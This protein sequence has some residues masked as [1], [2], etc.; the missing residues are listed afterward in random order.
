M[1]EKCFYDN[2]LV[3]SLQNLDLTKECDCM[4]KVN[5]PKMCYAASSLLLLG[6]II[7]T[8]VDYYRYYNTNTLTSAPFYLLVVVNI[9]YFIVPAIITL[10]IGIVVKCKQ[11]QTPKRRTHIGIYM[12]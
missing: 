4:K 6:F 1:C 11:K 7:H 8:I 2:M 10:V 5:V 9:A 12:L 3:N